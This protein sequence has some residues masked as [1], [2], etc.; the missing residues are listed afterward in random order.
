[1]LIRKN[2]KYPAGYPILSMFTSGLPHT[3]A[4]NNWGKMSHKL[5]HCHCGT[6]ADI[7]PL[8]FQR[9]MFHHWKQREN[10]FWKQSRT[11]NGVFSLPWSPH[12]GYD[13]QKRVPTL[14]KPAQQIK[15]IIFSQVKV[16]CE[17]RSFSVSQTKIKPLSHTGGN[18]IY[19]QSWLPWSPHS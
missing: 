11:N 8:R 6:I 1:M 15:L 4:L 12:Q 9:K 5:H 3:G 19:N 7:K 17:K 10:T 2:R 16:L 13:D 14:I 18:K